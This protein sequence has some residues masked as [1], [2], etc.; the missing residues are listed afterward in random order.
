MIDLLRGA[1]KVKR[2]P[3]GRSAGAG[4]LLSRSLSSGQRHRAK[5]RFNSSRRWRPVAAACSIEQRKIADAQGTASQPWG[6]GH[7]VPER[8]VSQAVARVAYS[9]EVLAPP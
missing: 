7:P 5:P 3:K 2:S 8:T 9:L 1:P 6:L 4:R